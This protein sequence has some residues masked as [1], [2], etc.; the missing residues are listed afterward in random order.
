M[1]T[2]CQSIVPLIMRDVGS[3][4]KVIGKSVYFTSR[5]RLTNMWASALVTLRHTFRFPSLQVLER[6]QQHEKSP[7]LGPVSPRGPSG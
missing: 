1:N 5:S 3:A 4:N 6:S 7:I 2:E